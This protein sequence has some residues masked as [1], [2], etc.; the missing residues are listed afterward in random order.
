VSLP[1][2]RVQDAVKEIRTI[3]VAAGAISRGRVLLLGS[4]KGGVGKSSLCRNILV[5]AAKQGLRIAGVDLDHQQTLAKWHARRDRVRQTYPEVCNVPVV[6]FPLSEWRQ[7]LKQAESYEL[8]VI[9]TPPS[10]E[11]QYS[12]SLSLCSAADLVLVP[13]GATQDDI[14]SCAP[15]MRTLTNGGIKSA[16]VL[17]KAN[18]RTKSYEAIRAKLLQ[19]GPLCPVEIPLLEDIHISSGKGLAVA[20]VSRSKAADTFNTLWSYTRREVGLREIAGIEEVA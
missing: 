10:I 11:Q 1:E 16:F 6:A 2:Y 9:D 19:S 18:R 3:M 8:I 5:S 7:A 14:D 15:W 17:N 12:G 13:T 20:D 4:P